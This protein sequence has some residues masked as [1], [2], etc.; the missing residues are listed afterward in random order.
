MGSGNFLAAFCVSLLGKKSS[1]A[2]LHGISG[3]DLKGKTMR[4]VQ[5]LLLTL[6]TVFFITGCGKDQE[7]IAPATK[8]PSGFHETATRG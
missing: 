4:F 1:H 2:P 5:S 3:F 7:R 6:A 8:A